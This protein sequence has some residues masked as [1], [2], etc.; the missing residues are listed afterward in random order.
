MR[1]EKG[2]NSRTLRT[3]P[4]NKPEGPPTRREAREI[5]EK[6]KANASE[7][8]SNLLGTLFPGQ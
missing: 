6:S 8:S 4:E 7:V 2:K 1:I 5:V 3:L